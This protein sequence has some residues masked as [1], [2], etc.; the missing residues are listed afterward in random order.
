M[1]QANLIQGAFIKDV[2]WKASQVSKLPLSGFAVHPSS[3]R[4]WRYLQNKRKKGSR[5]KIEANLI[6]CKKINAL[7]PNEVK[8]AKSK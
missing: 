3:L 6:N 1:F 5:R 7:R 2:R 8:W 4:V